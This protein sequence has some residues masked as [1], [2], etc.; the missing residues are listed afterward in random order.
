MPPARLFA[1][2]LRGCSCCSE[3]PR[4]RLGRAFVVGAGG[5]P[6]KAPPAPSNNHLQRTPVLKLVLHRNSS[7]PRATD[8]TQPPPL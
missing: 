5:G 3:M 2:A 4:P 1:A 7:P 6:P 8:E